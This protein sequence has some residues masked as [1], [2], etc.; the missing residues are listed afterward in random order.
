MGISTVLDTQVLAT[1]GA[2]GDVLTRQ[3]D[4]TY[5]A[6]TPSAGG[7]P[8]GSTGQIQ[9]NNAGAFGGTVA[10]VY[11]ASGTHFAVTAQAATDVPV[12][13]ELAAAQTANALNIET[14][15]GVVT[16]QITASGATQYG[17]SSGNDMMA[18]G[19]ADSG[20]KTAANASYHTSRGI[21]CGSSWT[22][23]ATTQQVA[24]V[25]GSSLSM[26][27][28]IDFSGSGVIR[29]TGVDLPISIKGYSGGGQAR[30]SNGVEIEGGAGGTGGTGN[31]RGGNMA[32]RS[33][34]TAGSA[35]PATITL[36]TSPAGSSG[37]GVQPWVDVLQLDSSTTAADT[38]MLLWDVDSAALVRVSVGADDSGGAGFKVLRIPN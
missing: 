5:L 32:I 6:E 30:V 24:Q 7:S 17:A 13:I 37:G 4:G 31:Y 34:K 23:R 27:L 12:T 14:S 33:G 35:T 3:A 15:A 20:L 9:Y 36:Q 25:S 11:A 22:L 26:Q 1:S 38:R 10:L 18:I 2:D 28:P 29:C 8:G 16:A 21:S 19:P